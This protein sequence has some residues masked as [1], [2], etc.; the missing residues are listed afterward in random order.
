MA[1]KIALDTSK[2]GSSYLDEVRSSVKN[3]ANH[4][5]TMEEIAKEL[6]GKW[7]GPSSKVAKETF[8]QNIEDMKNLVK[9][10]QALINLEQFALDKYWECE[11]RIG[12]LTNIYRLD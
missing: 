8:H 1:D 6:D 3:M 11:N 10:L 12:D 4:V 2:F 5:S 9:G 7:E